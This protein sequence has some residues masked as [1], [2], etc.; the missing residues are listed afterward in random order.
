[1]RIVIKLR[2]IY[3]LVGARGHSAVS[4]HQK[5][6][7]IPAYLLYFLKCPEKYFI[8]ENEALSKIFFSAS[9][10]LRHPNPIYARE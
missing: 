4:I 10:Q 7:I 1:M 6:T 8:K 3:I 9:E 2:F 5:R